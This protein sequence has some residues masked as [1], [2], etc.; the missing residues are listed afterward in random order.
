MGH[1]PVFSE[2]PTNRHEVV[3]FSLWN[4]TE[5]VN[6]PGYREAKFSLF[7]PSF[8]QVPPSGLNAEPVM[9]IGEQLLQHTGSNYTE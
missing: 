8:L 9:L 3:T 2:V 5:Q 6:K 7:I 1:W 4:P